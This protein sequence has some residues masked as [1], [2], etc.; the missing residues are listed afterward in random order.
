MQEALKKAGAGELK[1]FSE[2][3]QEAWKPLA[4]AYESDNG[5]AMVIEVKDVGLIARASIGGS[6]SILVPKNDNVF[7]SIGSADPAG[8]NKFERKD[9]VVT[10]MIVKRF[11]A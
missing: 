4:G 5:G 9:G 7:V 6:G 1:K 2:D 8:S 10:R 3:D 11:T